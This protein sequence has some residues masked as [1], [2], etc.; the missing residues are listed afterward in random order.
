M[1]APM[2]V[3]CSSRLPDRYDGVSWMSTS[4]IGAMFHYYGLAESADDRRA[5]LN[6]E[7]QWAEQRKA[8]RAQA[9]Y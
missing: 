2:R 6:R 4:R 1:K 7:R 3:T 9:G 8:L 5:R